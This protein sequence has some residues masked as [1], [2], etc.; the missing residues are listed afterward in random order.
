MTSQRDVGS[1]QLF[2]VII[3]AW[4]VIVLALAVHFQLVLASSELSMSLLWR[5]LL[6]VL[7]LNVLPIARFIPLA[8]FAAVFTIVI[9]GLLYVWSIEFILFTHP[10]IC[11]NR[12]VLSNFRKINPVSTR[13]EL[14]CLG[15]VGTVWLG[16]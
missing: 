10:S 9:M 11:S 13:I 3:L 16:E 1:Q 6:A 5:P 8:I 4:S 14:G 7:L 2:Q 15:V 12:L